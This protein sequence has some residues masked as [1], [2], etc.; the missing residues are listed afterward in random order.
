MVNPNYFLGYSSRNDK[1]AKTTGLM[2]I[3]KNEVAEM[4]VGSSFSYENLL[5]ENYNS[6]ERKAYS[7]DKIN[8]IIYSNGIPLNISFGSNYEFFK[9]LFSLKYNLLISKYHNY[10]YIIKFNKK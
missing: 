10:V 7:L 9:R 5:I 8:N 1:G 3:S 4:L 6:F 2:C